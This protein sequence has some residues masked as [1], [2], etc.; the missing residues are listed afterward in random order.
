[1]DVGPERKGP[2]LERKLRAGSLNVKEQRNFQN[3]IPMQLDEVICSMSHSQSSTG[4]IWKLKAIVSTF[5]GAV[6]S[7]KGHSSGHPGGLLK[8]LRV[9]PNTPV[10]PFP[11]PENGSVWLWLSRLFSV[12]AIPVRLPG[13]TALLTTFLHALPQTHTHFHQGLFKESPWLDYLLDGELY[14]RHVTFAQ[15]IMG[16]HELC[17]LL[18]GG[19]QGP[20][21]W[22]YGLLW[23]SSVY[24]EAKGLELSQASCGLSCCRVCP[25]AL[26]SSI[27]FLSR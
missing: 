27:V 12:P 4:L 17:T 10:F 7:G 3:L 1:M 25:M 2:G 22:G 8:A 16:N 5:N 14:H 18:K 6:C 15:W 9:W 19:Q 26:N 21:S 13:Y 24:S 20:T 11:D 23:A